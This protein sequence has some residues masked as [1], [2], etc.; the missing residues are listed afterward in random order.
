MDMR[1]KHQNL[2]PIRKNKNTIVSL[3][4]QEEKILN[5]KDELI[6][7]SQINPSIIVSLKKSKLFLRRTIANLSILYYIEC[8]RN[9]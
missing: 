5:I 6:S 9:Y 4:K 1:Q 3:L 7:N 2:F 8:D